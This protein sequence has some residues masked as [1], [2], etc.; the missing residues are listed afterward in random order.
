MMGLFD[1]LLGA[2]MS[3]ALLGGSSSLVDYGAQD[4]GINPCVICQRAGPHH[5]QIHSPF[6]NRKQSAEMGGEP[7]GMDFSTAARHAYAHLN[8]FRFA[9]ERTFVQEN[10]DSSIIEG[11]F[12]DVTNKKALPKL[13]DK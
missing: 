3:Q 9:Q 7:S 6:I 1:M 5:C 10:T 4:A 13:E 2:G 12:E 8:R 11:E